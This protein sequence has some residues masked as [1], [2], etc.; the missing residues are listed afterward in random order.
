ME[1]NNYF[2][3]LVLW[4]MAASVN[5]KDHTHTHSPIYSLLSCLCMFL[6]PGTG[7]T[8]DR[9]IAVKAVI[10]T[11]CRKCYLTFNNST[12]R[13]CNYPLLGLNNH[14]NNTTWE[15]CY[16]PPSSAR[17][18]VTAI[19]SPC[20]NKITILMVGGAL[21]VELELPISSPHTFLYW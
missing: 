10:G 8:Q 9:C 14:N 15:L 4:S 1:V 12:C 5:L 18:L 7:E 19:W 3:P 16:D 6:G 20:L 21:W 11:E 13:E 2:G 17:T